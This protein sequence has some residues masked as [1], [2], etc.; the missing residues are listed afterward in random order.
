LFVKIRGC[1]WFLGVNRQDERSSDGTAVR[2]ERCRIRPV[3]RVIHKLQ[4]RELRLGTGPMSVVKLRG[5]ALPQR[6]QV[7]SRWNLSLDGGPRGGNARHGVAHRPVLRRNDNEQS[8]DRSP[9]PCSQRAR[10]WPHL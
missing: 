5:P 10:K 1:V 4:L 9:Q 8:A 3:V 6:M 7:V 2:D